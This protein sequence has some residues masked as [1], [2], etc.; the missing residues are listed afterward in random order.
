MFPK[1]A[2]PRGLAHGFDLRGVTIALFGSL[3]L[4]G[5]ENEPP[6][7]RRG[8]G[9]ILADPTV[10]QPQPPPAPSGSRTGR[11]TGRARDRNC[12]DAGCGATPLVRIVAVR[13]CDRDE[14]EDKAFFWQVVPAACRNVMYPTGSKP[15][16]WRAEVTLDETGKISRVTAPQVPALQR[17][18]AKALVARRVSP[19][20][21]GP[22]SITLAWNDPSYSA[23]GHRK[24]SEE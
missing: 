14:V 4:A 10:S 19:K 21:F 6:T 22:C 12:G 11:A 18:I 23:K 8:R 5:C 13:G 3:A 7:Q 20:V 17:C 2:V 15:V 1:W 24:A 16:A 9:I